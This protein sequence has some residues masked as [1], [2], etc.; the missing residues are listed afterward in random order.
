MVQKLTRR[1]FL[2]GAAVTGALT[3]LVTLAG[4][5][6]RL[7]G[8]G[9]AEAAEYPQVD[10]A[11]YEIVDKVER[12]DSKNTA[13]SRREWDVASKN[14]KFTKG[15]DN[16]PA[17]TRRLKD[18]I[19]GTSEPGYDMRDIA[20]STTGT[21]LW[22]TGF[23]FMC[24][25]MWEPMLAPGQKPM[26]STPEEHSQTLKI[27]AKHFLA[28]TVGVC[29]VNREWLYTRRYH[30]EMVKTD[31]LTRLA[32]TL[33]QKPDVFGKPMT[34]AERIEFKAPLVDD[35]LPKEMKYAIVCGMEMDYEAYR[36]TPTNIEWAETTAT[37]SR[38]KFTVMHLA[39][40]INRL[41][42]RA[43]PFGSGG[44]GLCIPLAVDAGLGEMGRNG[45][46]INP[47]FGPRL[48]ICGV[49]TDMPLQPD[50]PIDMGVTRFC[51]TC[52]ICAEK[53]PGKALQAGER[54][55]NAKFNTTASGV[56]KWPVDGEACLAY[57]GKENGT[58]CGNCVHYCPYNKP[59]SAMHRT[60]AQFAP[61]MGSLFVKLDQAFGYSETKDVASWWAQDT[62]KW[63]G[64]RKS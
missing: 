39:E 45:L 32:R 51:Q 26:A 21:L 8:E 23:G 57:W 18:T 58:T 5:K 1:S 4:G 13:F 61:S 41:G 52:G 33:G 22:Y 24:T 54:T 47:D 64:P 28:D 3:G 59:N 37:Y 48:R 50:K 36:R 12:F 38:E 10:K 62:K 35:E 9:V 17:N 44:P 19:A 55:S 40:F 42:Y 14:Y 16:F 2:K 34:P 6:E 11:P 15:V 49:I 60:A 31:T 7:I 63:K 29:E 56:L 27:A 25:H 53:C 43:W 46:L 30:D 20:L